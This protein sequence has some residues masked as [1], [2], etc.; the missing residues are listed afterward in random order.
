MTRDEAKKTIGHA[1]ANPFDVRIMDKIPEGCTR[2]IE[3]NGHN[4]L[5]TFTYT[6]SEEFGVE[7][8]AWQMSISRY[9][10]ARVR[11]EDVMPL[12]PLLFFNGSDVYEAEPPEGFMNGQRHFY[13]VIK[14]EKRQLVNYN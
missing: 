11:K 5:L 2:T 3:I 10:T 13:Q 12:L 4:H 9:D 1:I 14:V 6:I 7:K 8:R